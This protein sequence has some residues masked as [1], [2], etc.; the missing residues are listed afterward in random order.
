MEI[1]KAENKNDY[2]RCVAIRTLVFIVEQGYTIESDFEN[3]DHWEDYLLSA[4]EKAIATARWKIKEPGTAKIGMIAV[5]K[6]VRGKGY[7][8]TLVEH[9]IAALESRKDVNAI[10]MSVQDHALPFYKKLGFEIIGSGYME[11]HVPHHK[12]IRGG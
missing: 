6:E 5:V 7:G 3:E 12:V 9:L 8:K 1:I 11:G 2:A 10:E 4:G